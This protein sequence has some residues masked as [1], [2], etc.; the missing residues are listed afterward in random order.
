MDE[1]FLFAFRVI[2]HNVLEVKVYTSPN[3]RS[4]HSIAYAMTTQCISNIQL[5]ILNPHL[6][7]VILFDDKR[8]V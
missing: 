2:S 1:K 7:E 6:G 3:L 8:G 4:V 5:R